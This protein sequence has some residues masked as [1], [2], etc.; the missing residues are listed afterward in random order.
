LKIAIIAINTIPENLF[1]LK[2]ILFYNFYKSNYL[3]FIT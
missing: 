1:I 3:I 2:K